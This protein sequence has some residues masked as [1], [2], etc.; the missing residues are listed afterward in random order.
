MAD[1]SHLCLREYIPLIF[2]L[3]QGFWCRV[4]LVT[5]KRSH[6]SDA[7]YPV[8]WFI[9]KNFFPSNLTHNSFPVTYLNHY[10]SELTKHK[11][12]NK[13]IIYIIQGVTWCLQCTAP[14]KVACCY[15][16]VQFGRVKIE[17]F[18]FCIW[19]TRPLVL[20]LPAEARSTS[21][22]MHLRWLFVRWSFSSRHFESGGR[23]WQWGWWYSQSS[24]YGH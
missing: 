6:S 4:S 1:W 19:T 20:Q 24:W 8:I 18:F 14:K 11:N 5:W 13:A 10:Q 9:S 7:A 3:D 21:P 22:P 2:D 16:V 12:N 23:G 17:H 15:W